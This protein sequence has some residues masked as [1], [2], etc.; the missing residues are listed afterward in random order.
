MTLSYNV[1][2]T[3]GSLIGYVFESML[4]AQIPN[5]CPIYPYLHPAVINHTFNNGQNLL[6]TTIAPKIS[7]STA[8]SILTS[9]TTAATTSLLPIIGSATTSS[10]PLNTFLSTIAATISQ[11]D[12]ITTK[13][14]M[15]STTALYNMTHNAVNSTFES[16]EQI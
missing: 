10:T 4:G 9:T 12:D 13:V 2:L 5:P 3:A 16:N 14:I 6:N 11:N 15:A 7:T 1:G 8:A